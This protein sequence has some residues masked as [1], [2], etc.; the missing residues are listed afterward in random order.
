MWTRRRRYIPFLIQQGKSRAECPGVTPASVGRLQPWHRQKT[1]RS[2]QPWAALFF[3]SLVRCSALTGPITS[4]AAC[5]YSILSSAILTHICF[6]ESVTKNRKEKKNLAISFSYAI[7]RDERIPHCCSLCESLIVWE[8]TCDF[9]HFYFSPSPSDKIPLPKR[10]A[11][12]A[13]V[14][15]CLRANTVK[16]MHILC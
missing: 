16:N 5:Q 1:T 15:Q 10:N 13:N 4:L 7:T 12:L 11:P 9:S 14:V 2:Y 3:E 6:G 8:L